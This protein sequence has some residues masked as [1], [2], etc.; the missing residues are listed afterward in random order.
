MNESNPDDEIIKQL[1]MIEIR[2]ANIES[3]QQNMDQSLIYYR[4]KWHTI[5]DAVT[6][7]EMNL[8]YQNSKAFKTIN[9]RRFEVPTSVRPLHLKST[10]DINELVNLGI[11]PVN[12]TRFTNV[13]LTELRKECVQLNKLLIQKYG[14]EF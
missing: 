2:V 12:S 3:M 14:D 13:Q 4:M 10:G 6:V 7:E 9:S 5:L 1:Q 11:A 8:N